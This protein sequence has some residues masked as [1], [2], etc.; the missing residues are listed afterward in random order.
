MFSQ[1]NLKEHL[2]NRAEISFDYSAAGSVNWKS[3][4]KAQGQ[5]FNGG[6]FSARTGGN[7]PNYTT[8]G[9]QAGQVQGMPKIV[10]ELGV[11]SPT[12]VLDMKSKIDKFT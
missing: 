2:N 7:K 11:T 8:K 10:A 1:Q 5:A 12:S 9:I 6:F 4:S 3:K